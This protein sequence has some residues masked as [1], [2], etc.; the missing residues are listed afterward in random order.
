MGEEF[1]A[2]VRSALKTA[3]ATGENQF[4][5]CSLTGGDTLI[6]GEGAAS[7]SLASALEL[8]WGKPVRVLCPTECEK[9][10]L[11]EKDRLVTCE[12]EIEVALE[13]VSCVIADPLFRPI[14]PE[15]VR[16]ISLPAESF[17]GRIFREEIPNLITGF[18]S[19][20]K[21]VL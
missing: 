9:G 10:I 4:P 15:G 2:L 16:F 1:S 17:S 20:A 7:V 13:N 21:E 19:F 3:A 14:V 11:R 18:E 8:S 12:E 6:I 5:Q